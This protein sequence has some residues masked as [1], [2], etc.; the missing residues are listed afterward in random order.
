MSERKDLAAARR[1]PA[2]LTLLTVRKVLAVASLVAYLLAVGSL[3]VAKFIPAK[4]LW[5]LLPLSA[6]GM[7]VVLRAQFQK[8]LSALKNI[9]LI[10]L[11]LLICGACVVAFS[12]VLS[13]SS[14]IAG[15][16]QAD[17]AAETYSIIAKKDRN[18][19]LHEAKTAA[20]LS[21]DQTVS[22]VTRELKKKTP[23]SPTQY[24]NLAAAT[25][26][27]EDGGV[28]TA[29]LNS[30]YMD[31][32]R[33]NSS[34]FYA[35]I[36]VLATF[37]VRAKATTASQVDVTQP[38]VLYI[39]GID[40]YGETST[41]S[42]SDVNMLAVVNPQTN[43]ILLVNTPRDYYI[44]L[45]GTTGVKDKLTHAG[46]Y[47]IDMSRQTLED[48]YST[49][50][51]AYLRVNF[52]SLVEVIDALGG[53]DVYSDY[54]FLTFHTGNNHVD[55][56][57]ALTFARERHSFNE[58]DR[59]RGKNQQ[60][61]I[62]AVVAK[63]NNPRNVLNYQAIMK[64]VKGA[65]QTNLSEGDLTKLINQQLDTM[66]AWST[67]SIAVDG[68][69]EMNATYSMGNQQLYVMIPDQAT[70]DA[71]KQKIADTLNGRN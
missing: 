3:V 13:L 33:E 15:V 52:D 53:V 55:G 23:A 27:L 45:H 24:D 37:T 66:K 21:D 61:V 2:T 5:I 20:L 51:S 56:K 58:G 1:A 9:W 47:G 54:D 50:I 25:V 22:E 44:Q 63:L 65:V 35:S 28:D 59:Q 26:A 16:Q 42:R 62:E 34:A 64:A 70:V 39:S 43:K 18:M 67:E 12:T 14:F 60:H 32:V 11:S 71:A 46:L 48:L 19:T 41:V 38:F 36:E 69:G 4:Y 30:G 17:Y 6:I 10:V 31:I 40:A 29:V 49:Q 8:N 68:T 57:Q 7:A